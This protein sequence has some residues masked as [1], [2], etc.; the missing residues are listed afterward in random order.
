MWCPIWTYGAASNAAEQYHFANAF[1]ATQT[2]E[3]RRGTMSETVELPIFGLNGVERLPVEQDGNVYTLLASPGMVEG[4]AAGDKF[5]L[6]PGSDLG[7]EV[8]H[9]GGNL[10]AW[11]FFPGPISP[12]EA[13]SHPLTQEVGVL[14]GQLD[15]GGKKHVVYTIPGAGRFGRV[16]ELFN[17]WT[18]NI[19]GSSWMFGNVYDPHD[20][21]TRLSWVNEML[22]G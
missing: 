18:K 6:R 15:G 10:C 2:A 7:F 4:L 19:S 3:A 12:S 16:V 21:V 17:R 8:V 9:R 14:G 20:G 1:D 5:V 13:E 11:F 22:E